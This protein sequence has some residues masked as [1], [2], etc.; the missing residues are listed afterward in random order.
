MTDQP[1]PP[2]LLDPDTKG[3]GTTLG[4]T[5]PKS[6]YPRWVITGRSDVVLMARRLFQDHISKSVNKL[7]T[8]AL[9][10]SFEDVVML[11]HRFPIRLSGSANRYWT[12]WIEDLR[13]V[14]LEEQGFVSRA[15]DAMNANFTG[16]LEPFQLEGVQFLTRRK[17]AILADEMGLGKTV[18]ALAAAAR[19][20]RWPVLIVA[21]PHVMEHW[22]RK[23]AEFLDEGLR[24][25]LLEGRGPK[26]RPVP[27]ADIYIT[28]Y[29]L[30]RH[31]RD[32]LVRREFGAVIYDECQEL[33]VA[34]SKKTQAA[35]A[36][37]RRAPHVWGLSGT[38]IYNSGIEAHHIYDAISP[39]I[40]GPRKSFLDDWCT[41]PP[42]MTQDQWDELNATGWRWGYVLEPKALG[43]YLR[44][45]GLLLRRLEDQVKGELPRL[46]RVTK[47]LEHDEGVF[48]DLI[49]EAARL[50]RKA[51]ATA[52]TFER[53]KYE[54]M[55]INSARRATGVA[56]ATAAATFVR[57]MV[58]SGKPTIIFAHHH[59][60]VDTIQRELQDLTP[61]RIT[62]RENRKQ[63]ARSQRAFEDGLTD[64]II[65]GLRSAT[66]LDGLQKRAQTVMFAELDWSPAIHQQG[67]KRAHRWGQP[68]EVFSYYMVASTL[69]DAEMLGY[70]KAKIIQAGQILHDEQITEK[71]IK[72]DEKAAERH[73]QRMLELLRGIK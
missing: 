32:W 42:N 34:T 29:L 62:G 31:W 47:R 45:R 60:V 18:Q 54:A 66:G 23:S 69:F 30:L 5:T 16:T 59:E 65:I 50:A 13:N 35:Q 58:E 7:S 52:K 53:A 46:R 11:R 70:L 61:V 39:G 68:H 25:Q 43:T 22:R 55:A 10:E 14:W 51:H 41:P 27:K 19:V 38:P 26:G 33:R 44:D 1:L 36:V 37:S 72:A 21:Q 28:H 24:V 3:S 12:D 8:P 67:E 9:R 64:V 40:L 63:K 71:E 15:D 2:F 73:M 56:K 49:K 17:K 48:G 4:I 20:G 6:G 57:G